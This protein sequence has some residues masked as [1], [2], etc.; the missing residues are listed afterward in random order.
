M[1][2][3]DNNIIERI[4]RRFASSGQRRDLLVC[5]QLLKSSPGPKET[6]QLMAG[7]EVAFK[8]R[9]LST[10]P[11]ELAEAMAASGGESISLGIRRTDAEAIEQ[12]LKIA[13][14]R[15]ANADLRTTYLQ[16]LAE[17]KN[18]RVLPLLLNL[19]SD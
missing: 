17:V 8:G 10:I 12:G 5:A 14:D 3:A 19:V 18:P 4:M 13:A 16:T 2:V 6:K 15:A 11:S 7:F 1:P 9:S